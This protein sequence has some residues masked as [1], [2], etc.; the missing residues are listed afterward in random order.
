M[1]VTKIKPKKFMCIKHIEIFRNF[2]SSEFFV[3]N[4]IFNI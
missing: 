1:F 4:I 2:Y 3:I